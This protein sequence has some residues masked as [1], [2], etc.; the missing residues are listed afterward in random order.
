MLWHLPTVTDIT[1]NA[2]VTWADAG[3]SGGVTWNQIGNNLRFYFSDIDQW[4]FF[5]V[6]ITNSCGTINLRYRFNSTAATT[7]GGPLLRVS[8]SP[9]PSTNM[10]NITLTEKEG[11]KNKK[12]IKQIKIVDKLGNTKQV[13]DYNNLLDANVDVANLPMDIYTIM[14]FDGKQWYSTKFIKN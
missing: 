9:N 8:V 3:N 7:C 11:L 4:A 10:V 12:E 1:A 2:S 13:K 5:S 14:V 6:T